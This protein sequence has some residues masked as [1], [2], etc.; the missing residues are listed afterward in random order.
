MPQSFFHLT[1][2]HDAY[3][4]HICAECAATQAGEPEAVRQGNMR[5]A[6]ALGDAL[7][8]ALDAYTDRHDETTYRHCFEALAYMHWY[9]RREHAEEEADA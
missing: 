5:A 9:L 7:L 2:N 4:L 3:G 1:P 6:I 8:E